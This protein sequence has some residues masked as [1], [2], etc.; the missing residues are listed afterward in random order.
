MNGD[1]DPGEIYDQFP[2]AEDREDD[3]GPPPPSGWVW[4]NDPSKFTDTA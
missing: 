3:P 2:P 1:V 4:I